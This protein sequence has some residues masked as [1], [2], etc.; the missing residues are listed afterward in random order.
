VTQ[1]LMLQYALDPTEN[2][3]QALRSH[4]G[5][6]RLTYNHAL[7]EIYQN[8]DAV[9]KGEEAEYLKANHYAIRK[10]FN[11]IKE[12]KYPWWNENSKEAYSTGAM[13]AARAFQ[14]FFDGRSRA[15][16]YKK[17]S[18]YSDT[19]GIIFTTGVRRLDDNRHFT[20][21]RIGKI[22]LHENAKK[23]SWLLHNDAKIGNVTVKYQQSR[24]KINVTMQVPD[25]LFLRYV[26]QRTKRDKKKIVGIDLGIRKAAVFSDGTVIEN[27][28]AFERNVRKLRRLN[29]ELSRRK[30][31]NRQ[32]GEVASHRWMKTKRKLEKQHGKIVNYRVDHAHKLSRHVVDDFKVIGL[33]DL[34]VRGMIQGKNMGRSVN[35][36]NFGRIRRFIEYK[37]AWY[38]SQVGFVDR[39]YPSSKTCS[40]CGEVKAK[41]SRNATVFSCDSCGHRMD[42]DLNAALNIERKVAQSYGETLNGHGD[43]GSG[44]D[45]SE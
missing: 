7:Y 42:R 12:E 33:E 40:N 44:S 21:P 29:K 10:R 26:D 14:N 19:E 5:A 38:G 28:K 23:L 13:N 37:S 18:P 35:D 1:T 4:A 17:K 41:L 20:L 25:D 22:R 6:V 31:W 32:T 16:K 43:D 39:F 11:K 36:A 3:E 9:K 2:Q 24:W 15:P 27:P 34:N 30:K 8:W 45:D